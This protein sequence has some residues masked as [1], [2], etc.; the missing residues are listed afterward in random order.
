MSGSARRGASKSRLVYR[1]PSLETL[2]EEFAKHGMTDHNAQLFSSSAVVIDAPVG[3]IWSVLA[4]W[5]RAN[6]RPSSPA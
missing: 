1:G 5:P 6:E 2:H 3:R 4:A